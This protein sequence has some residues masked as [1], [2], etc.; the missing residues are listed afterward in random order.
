MSYGR[1]YDVEKLRGRIPID[2]DN[3]YGKF[4]QGYNFDT[5]NQQRARV[6]R[7]GSNIPGVNTHHTKNFNIFQSPVFASTG[8]KDKISEIGGKFPDPYEQ[9]AIQRQSIEAMRYIQL[10]NPNAVDYS[11]EFDHD[12]KALRKNQY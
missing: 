1:L 10:S 5:S 3:Y 9:Q 2:I 11:M 8:N 7:H 12:G 4:N 6:R